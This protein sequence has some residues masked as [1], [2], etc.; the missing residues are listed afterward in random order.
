VS[1]AGGSRVTVVSRAWSWATAR[2]RARPASRRTKSSP[3]RSAWSQSSA[4][5][6]QAVV[7][8]ARP[9]PQGPPA[10]LP[11]R[12]IAHDASWSSGGRQTPRGQHAAD[13]RLAWR[14]VGPAERVAAHPERGQRVPSAASLSRSASRSRSSSRLR[15][16]RLARYTSLSYPVTRCNPVRGHRT[17]AE[18]DFSSRFCWLSLVVGLP[19]LE[20]GT[21][22]LSGMR[23]NRLSYRPA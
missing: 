13:G 23:S 2:W 19:G 5:R 10:R 11:L 14:P 9:G 4:S 1:C 8:P 12:I 16:R 22:S 17:G 6:C 7:L 20:P 18:R 21:S 15:Q 3:P